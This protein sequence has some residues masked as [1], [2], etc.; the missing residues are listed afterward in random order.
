MELSP[1]KQQILKL[2]IDDYIT[3]AEPVGS[4]TLLS[5]HD[6]GVSSATI[7]NEMA[8]LESLGFL[9]QPH[10]SA[11]RAPTHSGYRF[12][13]DSLMHRSALAP[14]EAARFSSVLE[15]KITNHDLLVEKLSAVLSDL[16][17]YTVA[18]LRPEIKKAYL[19]HIE[20]LP[21]D[22]QNVVIVIVTGEGIVKN[23]LIR[24]GVAVQPQFIHRLSRVLR[25]KL[26]GLS[27]AEISL[28]RINEIR[29]V[30]STN[31]SVL[32]PVLGFISEVFEHEDERDVVLEGASNLFR[33]PEYQDLMRMQA[34]Y[35]FLESKRGILSFLSETAPLIRI[36]IGAENG[37]EELRDCSTVTGT[38]RLGSLSAGRL[39]VIGPT[40][41]NYAKVVGLVDYLTRQLSTILHREEGNH[42]QE[43]RDLAR[44]DY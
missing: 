21:I 43:T 27:M 44:Y 28:S 1:R 32:D 24:M 33:F 4:K 14:A 10:T 23:K 15:E 25:E 37:Y 7:R 31:H 39:A 13:V 41:M 22:A 6:M 29:A 20:L 38:Y 8:E 30:M 16:T 2:V 34:F 19:R 9:E 12:Y 35:R 11:G 42:E 18:V 17:G 3:Y 26:V 40:R 36:S 5:R